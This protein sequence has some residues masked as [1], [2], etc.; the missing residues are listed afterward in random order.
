M[1]V[2]ADSPL[3]DMNIIKIFLSTLKVINLILLQMLIL[4][5]SQKDNQ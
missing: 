2:S 3:L 4:G 1:R 5:H